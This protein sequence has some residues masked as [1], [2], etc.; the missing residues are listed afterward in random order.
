MEAAG[1]EKVDRNRGGA[2][3]LLIETDGCLEGIRAAEVV[4][5][6]VDGSCGGRGAAGA[7]SRVAGIAARGQVLEDGLDLVDAVLLIGGDDVRELDDALVL[8][9]DSDGLRGGL[10]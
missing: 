5:Q 10:R 2:A 4:G 7:A 8:V 3:D 9:G 1:V 6:R